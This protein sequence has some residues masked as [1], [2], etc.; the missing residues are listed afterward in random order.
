MLA[1]A[2]AGDAVFLGAVLVAELALGLDAAAAVMAARV[3]PADA[4]GAA[5]VRRLPDAVLEVRDGWSSSP[6]SSRSSV[7]DARDA[8]LLQSTPA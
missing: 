3:A 6:K 8:V 7:Y 1:L 5:L 4:A 2:G